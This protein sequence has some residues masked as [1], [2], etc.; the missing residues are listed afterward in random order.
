MWYDSA[1]RF[2][3]LH[4]WLISK[5]VFSLLYIHALTLIATMCC[6]SLRDRNSLQICDTST[7]PRTPCQE[8]QLEKDLAFVAPL[9]EQAYGE[10]DQ[11]TI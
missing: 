6:V 1:F 11:D 8:L 3:P 2:R 7:V 10:S 5:Q 9:L 4:T